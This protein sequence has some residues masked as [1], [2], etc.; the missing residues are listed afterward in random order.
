MPEKAEND[1][2]KREEKSRLQAMRDK[3][4]NELF[5]PETPPQYFNSHLLEYFWEIGPTMS[6]SMGSSPLTHGE[7]ESWQRNIGIKLSAWECRTLKKLSIEYSN[8]SYKAT[9]RDCPPPW[10]PEGYTIDLS[11]V[12]RDLE[13]EVEALIKF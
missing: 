9:K 11:E 13:S 5:N 2:S 7:I 6:G 1:K 3:E 10:K 4:K 12:A 8:Q